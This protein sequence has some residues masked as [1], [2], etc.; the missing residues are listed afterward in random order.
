VTIIPQYLIFKTL[1]WVDTL[2]PMIAPNW[3][4]SAYFIFLLRQFFLT[5]P[6]EMDDAARI[7]GCSSLGV[8]VRIVLP[9]SAPA[10]AVVAL[11]EFLQSWNDFFRPIIFLNSIENFTVALGLQFFMHFESGIP[12]WHYLMAASVVST[13]PILIIFFFLQRLFIQGVVISGVKG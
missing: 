8:Y 12:Q 7:D 11:Y 4:G 10:L 9:L 2:L 6:L 5:I 3:F 13:L 1:G